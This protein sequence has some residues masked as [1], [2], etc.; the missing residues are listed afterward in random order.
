MENVKN[1]LNIFFSFAIFPS[2]CI[3]VIY[4]FYG[5]RTFFNLLKIILKM[6]KIRC[7]D[8]GEIRPV[9]RL[10]ESPA[11]F[12]VESRKAPVQSCSPAVHGKRL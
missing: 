11:N 8:R 7:Y 3:I 12:P 5:K 9:Q 10:P 1:C 6:L 2:N 4:Y